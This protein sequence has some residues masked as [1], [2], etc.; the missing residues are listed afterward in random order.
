M[1]A[2]T[3]DKKIENYNIEET[4]KKKVTCKAAFFKIPSILFL[5]IEIMIIEL[6]FGNNGP[7]ARTICTNI[8]VHQLCA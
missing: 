2:K 8:F 1:W 6:E 3:V 4:R 7:H 5:N